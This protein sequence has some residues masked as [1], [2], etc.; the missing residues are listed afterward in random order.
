MDG[1]TVT[2]RPASIQWPLHDHWAL[3]VGWLL[4]STEVRTIPPPRQR[5][6]AEFA[7]EGR[8]GSEFYCPQNHP[9][10]H[11]IHRSESS[12]AAKS[13]YQSM[14]LMDVSSQETSNQW[15]GQSLGADNTTDSLYDD[16]SQISV[17]DSKNANADLTGALT[18][19][20]VSREMVKLVNVSTRN[21]CPG[22][23]SRAISRWSHHWLLT[24]EWPGERPKQRGKKPIIDSF[25]G[26]D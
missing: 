25:D 19:S 17:F 1:A 13:I 12:G 21:I 11:L 4:F 8:S 14:L 15:W 6:A 23:V 5:T 18:S 10:A 3:S 22:I 24:N 26:W 20:G 16:A 2:W 7:F 9:K